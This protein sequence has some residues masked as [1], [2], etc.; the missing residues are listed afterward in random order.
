MLG[1]IRDFYSKNQ[2]NNHKVEKNN[3][4][5]DSRLRFLGDL[6]VNQFCKEFKVKGKESIKAEIEKHQENK[7]IIVSSHF[8]NLD[9]PAA[10]KAL[11][12]IFDLQITAQS[13]SFKTFAPQNLLFSVGGKENFIPLDYHQ[14][15]NHKIG[16]FN[17]QNF[18]TVLA[19]IDHNKTPW[20]A[21]HAFNLHG[22]MG[23]PNIGSVYLA[24]KSKTKI[25]PVGLEMRGYSVSLEG[26]ANITQ[27]LAK[28]SQGK[29]IFHIGQPISLEP[30][31]NLELIDIVLEKRKKGTIISKEEKN[32]FNSVIKQLRQQSEFVGQAIADMLPQQ[33]KG[34]YSQIDK[35]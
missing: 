16:V 5:T 8:S 4:T 3:K 15:K 28:R 20:I 11:G 29:V 6:L 19:R 17:P 31:K 34:Y 35:K 21:A 10:I 13:L 9:A 2:D 24:Q 30:I 26:L 7:Y 25:I 22:A 23:K 33:H 14:T 12:D 32:Q 18:D 27:G 1:K